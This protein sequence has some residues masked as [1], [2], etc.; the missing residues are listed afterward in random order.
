MIYI[1]IRIKLYHKRSLFPIVCT[2]T[3]L[4]SSHYTT[5]WTLVLSVETHRWVATGNTRSRKAAGALAGTGPSVNDPDPGTRLRFPRCRAYHL[6]YTRSGRRE[7]VSTICLHA[8]TRVNIS[9]SR[10]RLPG[11][12]L[13][14]AF[15][16]PI[17]SRCQIGSVYPDIIG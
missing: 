10:G 14:S 5:S 16:E 13:A 6:I 2:N 17:E 4:N 15:K 11:M 3:L 1:L 8:Q 7:R 9:P 12:T